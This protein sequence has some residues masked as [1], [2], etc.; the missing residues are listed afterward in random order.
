MTGNGSTSTYIDTL[1]QALAVRKDWLEKSEL[2]KLKETT[3][4]FHTSYTSL[5]NIF[6]KKKLINEDPYKEEAKITELQAPDTGVLNE[7]KRGEQMSIRLANFDNQLDFLANFYQM[8]VD[9]LNLERVRRIL[10][11]VRFIDWVNLSPDSQSVNTSIV[12]EMTSKAKANVDKITFSIIA[13]SLSNLAK[14]T[15]ALMG[16]LKNLTVYYKEDYKLAVRRTITNSMDANSANVA[17]I[18]KK[19]P[20][21]L[22][23]TIF[24]QE[25]IE[26]IIREDFSGDGDELKTAIIKALQIEAEKPKVVKPAINFKAIL[27]EGTKVIGG[28]NVAMT[29]ILSKIDENAAVLA[30]QK[31]GF[32]R[33]LAQLVKQLVNSEPEDVYYEIQHIEQNKTVPVRETLNF[34]KFRNEFDKK[35]NILAS[36]VNGP[37]AVKLSNMT[38]DQVMGYLDKNIRDVQNYHKTLTALDDYFKAKTPDPDRAK[39]KGIKPELSTMKNSIIK[40]NQLRFNYTSLKEEEEQM[41]RLGIAHLT[42]DGSSISL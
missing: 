7:A 5:Y 24:Y 42:S 1:A 18:K 23:K 26:E 3:R 6:L 39:I 22:P 31:K 28:A 36:F 20:A 14:G 37:A 15:V 38:E 25:L 9:F 2:V 33:T 35:T 32:F 16:I 12:A 34:N 27:L 8:R 13:E 10:G 11:L 17:N 30:S 40:A 21:A 41:K 4:S 29:E 19:F